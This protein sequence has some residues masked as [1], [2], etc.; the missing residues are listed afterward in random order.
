MMGTHRRRRRTIVAGFVEL[1]RVGIN[2]LYLVP[3]RVG[4]TEIYARELV[5]ALAAKHADVAFSAFCGREAAP[6][7]PGVP[8][9]ANARARELPVRST[10]KPLRLAAELGL[11]PVAAR[12]A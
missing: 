1:Q 10:S 11:L 3:G 9:P 2:V 4:G 8:C 12:R 5:G 7:L 6:V